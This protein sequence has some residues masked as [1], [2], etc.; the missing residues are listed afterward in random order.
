MIALKFAT[1]AAATGAAEV[2]VSGPPP[3]G[4]PEVKGMII[5]VSP[6]ERQNLHFEYFEG[7]LPL[8]LSTA[9]WEFAP[10][11][12]VAAVVPNA[13]AVGTTG[14]AAESAHCPLHPKLNECRIQFAMGGRIVLETCFQEAEANVS[15]FQAPRAAHASRLGIAGR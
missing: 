5:L 1:A 10:A 4:N 7:A 3:S 2:V 8:V 14:V 11:D 13:L 9:D 15:I 12:I 6:P